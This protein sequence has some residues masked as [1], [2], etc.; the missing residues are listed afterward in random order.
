MANPSSFLK[1]LN[2]KK[3]YIPKNCAIYENGEVYLITEI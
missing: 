2:M 3:V 1:I